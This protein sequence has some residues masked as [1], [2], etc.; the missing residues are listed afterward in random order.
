MSA[1]I[2]FLDIDGV[3]NSTMYWWRSNPLPLGQAGAIDPA[4]VAHLNAIVARTAPTIVLSSAWRGVD[5]DGHVRVQAMLA[6]RGFA[7]ML[8]GQTPYLATARHEEIAAWLG[9]H[10][11]WQRFAVLDD[12]PEAWS[13]RVPFTSA[14][15]HAPTNYL[16][17]MDGRHVEMIC[18]WFAPDRAGACRLGVPGDGQ[19]P[20]GW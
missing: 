20:S 14:G 15:L 17:G 8:S 5:P 18:E 19:I 1:N 2:L 13:D 9:E 4:A 3:L 12:D 11:G 16:H 10:D 7:G 6:E